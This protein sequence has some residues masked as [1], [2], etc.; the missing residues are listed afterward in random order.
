MCYLSRTTPTPD[1]HA[2]LGGARSKLMNGQLMH[3]KPRT[4]Y[5]SLDTRG[6]LGLRSESDHSSAFKLEICSLRDDMIVREGDTRGK[7]RN[8]PVGGSKKDLN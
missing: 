3:T 7:K 2:V 5:S 8:G 4:S 1:A 6:H